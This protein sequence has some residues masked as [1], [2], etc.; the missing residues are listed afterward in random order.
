M[1][2]QPAVRRL[3]DRLD[4]VIDAGQADGLHAVVVVR[5]GETLLERYGAGADFTWGL[6][7]V[8]GGVRFGARW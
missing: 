7:T 8:V 3:R 5:G 6:P 4:E 1:S 2:G